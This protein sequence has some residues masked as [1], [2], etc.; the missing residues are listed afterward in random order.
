VI[1]ILLKWAS[2]ISCTIVTLS[3][4]YFAVDQSS[5]ASATSVRGI[6]GQLAGVKPENATKL[7]NPPPAIEKL[8][9]AEND[10][11]HEYVDDADDILLSPFTGISHSKNIWARRLIPLV[12]ALLIYGVLAMYLARAAGL[13][14][15]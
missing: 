1:A 15:W 11:F 8:R 13:R 7:P 4:L 14:R 5:Q 6:T 10:K 2:I 12:L 9:E 3:F